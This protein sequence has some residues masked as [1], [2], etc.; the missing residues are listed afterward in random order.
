M[1]LAILGVLAAVIVTFV[2]LAVVLWFLRRKSVLAAGEEGR[3]AA[4]AAAS[5]ISID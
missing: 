1:I 2:A 3:A 5:H 4:I